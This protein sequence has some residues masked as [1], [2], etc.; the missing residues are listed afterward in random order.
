MS[1]GPLIVAVDSNVLAWATR[2]HEPESRQEQAHWLLMELDSKGAVVLAPAVA[3]AEILV[4]VPEKDRP[5][6]LAALSEGFTV[7][8][9]DDRATVLAAKLMQRS[10]DAR[11]KG[12]T[13]ARTK[14]KVDAMVVA[15]AKSAGATVFYS[16]DSLC[17]QLA[18]SA[19]LVAKA[20]PDI[21][22]SL[23]VDGLDPG[24]TALSS[25]VRGRDPRK[26]RRRV[27]APART[28]R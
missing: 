2:A 1:D 16:N 25:V 11:S 15:T 4:P 24:E 10:L 26:K 3:V 23:F 18:E 20:L 7:V 19:G 13:G 8:P 22:P 21:A 27:E 14:A 9:L 12:E 28:T 6:V 5:R 17:R